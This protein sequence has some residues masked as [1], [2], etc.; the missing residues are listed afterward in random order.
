MTPKEEG[1]D[2]ESK[3]EWRSYRNGFCRGNLH[4]FQKKEMIMLRN[5][6]RLLKEGFLHPFFRCPSGDIAEAKLDWKHHFESANFNDE[7]VQF[8][9]QAVDYKKKIEGRRRPKTFLGRLRKF[10]AGIKR[11]VS[12]KKVAP[13]LI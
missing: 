1:E 11:L 7:N 8:Y 3:Q 2:Q 5:E 10:F 9:I 6:N 12:S 4:D 13:I